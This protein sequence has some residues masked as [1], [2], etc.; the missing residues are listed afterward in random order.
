MAMNPR[1]LRPTR[2]PLLLDFAPGAAAA[3]SLR[4]LSS[5]YAGPVVTVRRSSDDVEDSFTAQEVSDGT[6]AAFC[7]A[8]DGFVKTWHDQSGNGRDASQATSGSQPKIVSSGVVVQKNSRPALDFDGSDD[9]M[10]SSLQD[11]TTPFSFATVFTLHTLG[12]NKTLFGDWNSSASDWYWQYND[13]FAGMVLVEDVHSTTP[14][15]VDPIA[16]DE[17][18]MFFVVNGAPNITQSKNG[19]VRVSNAVTNGVALTGGNGLD[20]GALGTA[21]Q[22]ADMLMQEIVIWDFDQSASRQRIEGNIAWSYSV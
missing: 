4:Q 21:L 10:S 9:R 22:F 19:A 2:E 12:A 17:Q 8:N 7:G 14:T 15:V 18:A 5:G 3:Y 1:L 16:V 6:L 20:I 11:L 13:T